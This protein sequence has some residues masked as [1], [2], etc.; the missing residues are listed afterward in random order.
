M[1][2]NIKIL[3]KKIVF[4]KFEGCNCARSHW[5]NYLN[6]PYICLY[7]LFPQTAS[8]C[9]PT[10]PNLQTNVWKIRKINWTSSSQATSFKLGEC[11]LLLSILMLRFR[12]CVKFNFGRSYMYLPSDSYTNTVIFY[13]FAYP[14]RWCWK[15]WEGLSCCIVHPWSHTVND[16]LII[17]QSVTM[18]LG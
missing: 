13:R 1:N 9:L 3:G 7:I 11:N 18:V 5:A 14:S 12:N 17:L 16:V 6:F 2:Q 10:P 8:R 4:T 15:P